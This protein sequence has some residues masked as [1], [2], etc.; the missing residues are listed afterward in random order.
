MHCRHLLS[1]IQA[2][3]ACSIRS[4]AVAALQTSV[5]L[6]GVHSSV[7]WA[8]VGA[9]PSARRCRVG[10]HRPRAAL[11]TRS[12]CRSFLAATSCRGWASSGPSQ[13]TGGLLTALGKPACKLFPPQLFLQAWLCGYKCYD[14]LH[15]HALFT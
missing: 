9:P 4:L 15:P 3:A 14:G 2:Q 13:R 10:L 7:C 1:S 5:T 11:R 6:W 8:C 12:R